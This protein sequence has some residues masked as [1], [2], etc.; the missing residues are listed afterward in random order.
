ME[1]DKT[2]EFEKI[3]DMLWHLKFDDIHVTTWVRLGE[4]RLIY[5]LSQG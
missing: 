5:L 4:K 1:Q 3:A 2:T